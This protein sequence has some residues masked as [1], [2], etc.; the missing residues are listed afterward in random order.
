MPPRYVLQ[1]FVLAGHRTFPARKFETRAAERQLEGK[2]V[3]VFSDALD[4]VS[5]VGMSKAYASSD[6]GC[7]TSC[8]FLIRYHCTPPS[9]RFV[10]MIV[11][12][13]ASRPLS[14]PFLKPQPWREASRSLH[15]RSFT[16]LRCKIAPGYE[17]IRSAYVGHE[18]ELGVC[19][20]D[21]RQPSRLFNCVNAGA[22]M[23][24]GRM[25]SDSRSLVSSLAVP[26]KPESP[27]PEGRVRGIK[28][29]R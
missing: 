7:A 5:G 8:K 9:G 20:I 2:Q 15:R 25:L 14:S 11:I 24:D 27:R 16:G 21:P 26:A 22:T 18:S 12:A 29:C 6:P 4:E 19:Q 28:S 13:G 3:R 10:S 1:F 17:L 23:G